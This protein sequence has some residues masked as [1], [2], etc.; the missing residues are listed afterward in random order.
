MGLSEL[1]SQSLA[2][3]NLKRYWLPNQVLK[4]QYNMK[5]VFLSA[6]VLLF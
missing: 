5:K 3:L 4:K 6:T 1:W 2:S